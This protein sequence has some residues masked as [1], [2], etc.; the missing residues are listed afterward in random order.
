MT[1]SEI[2]QLI[3]DG[4][5][6]KLIAQAYSEIASLKIKRIRSE[7]E[8]NRLFFE[9]VSFVYGMVKK[10]A[11]KKRMI[12]PKA[13]KRVCLLLGSNYRFYGNINYSVI[14][15]FLSQTQNIETDRIVIG[16]TAIDY[17]RASKI[18]NFQQVVLKD[19]QPTLEELNYLV[20]RIQDY[21]Q[22]LV[23][24]SKL[25]TLLVQEPKMSDITA[26][27]QFEEGS[28][29]VDFSFI[30]EPELPKILAFFDS[31]I[32]TLLLEQTFLESE[33]ARTASRFI[34]MDEAETEANKFIKENQ[35]LKAYA[36]KSLKNNQILEAIAQARKGRTVEL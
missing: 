27:T 21:A 17:F 4:E 32:L 11:S 10:V 7:V 16:K 6:L 15:F 12:F 14:N 22:V 5:S 26:S 34:S 35:I 25:K 1:I 31:S 13:K 36:Q 8:R 29:Q 24:Y 28:S 3:E 2:E 23:F 30:F 19:D 9:E 18:A 33:L 20:S